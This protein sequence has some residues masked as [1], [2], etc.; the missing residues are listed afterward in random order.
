MILFYKQNIAVL[1]WKVETTVYDTAKR[2]R[3]MNGKRMH[4]V[5]YK[6]LSIFKRGIDSG[7]K[8]TD[9]SFKTRSA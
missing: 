8:D 9:N 2:E 1:V 6:T 7:K 3:K 5:E 4:D